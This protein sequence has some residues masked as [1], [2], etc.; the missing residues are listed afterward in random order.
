M[1]AYR[2]PPLTVRDRVREVLVGA[3]LTEVVTHS[4]V[5]PEQLDRFAPADDAVV[6]GEGAVDGRPVRVVNPLSSQHSVL[7]R[8]LIGSLVDV[9]AN[10]RR[11]GRDPVAIFEIGKGYGATH[12][13]RPHE[14][15]RVGFALVGRIE[16]PRW[17]AS[18][19]VYDLDDAKGVVEL[20]ARTLLLPAPGWSP[21]SDD[22]DLHPGR[23]AS[24]RAGDGLAGSVGEL[25]P[26]R[27]DADDGEGERV[28]VGQF[29]IAGI[30]G[31]FPSVPIVSTPPRHPAV[32]RDL[33]V[34][35]D[36]TV[37][38]ASTAGSIASHAGEWLVD[39]QLFDIY[40]GRP[41]DPT[42]KSLAYRLTFRDPERTLTEDEVD[43][44]LASIRQ[45]LAEDVSGR[46]RS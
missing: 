17:D 35:V 20:I 34:V 41:L 4:L 13:G 10:N 46:I 3:G 45:G 8:S 29:A 18:E 31:G 9:V 39:A 14:W 2:R 37:A 25:H 27:L 16:P 1:P 30:S 38:A 26:G 5:A 6:P 24:V 11:H 28:I 19:R 32:I 42:E 23:S 36:E 33:A 7:R 21:R 44:A 22:P 15:W 40:R 43:G 12:D